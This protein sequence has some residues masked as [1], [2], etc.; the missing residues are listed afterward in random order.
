MEK[1]GRERTPARERLIDIEGDVLFYRV[2]HIFFLTADKIGQDSF[3]FDLFNIGVEIHQE[4]LFLRLQRLQSEI[5]DLFYLPGTVAHPAF[6]IA[7]NLEILLLISKHYLLLGI[8]FGQ[9]LGSIVD[10]RRVTVQ[11]FK[12]MRLGDFRLP[13]LFNTYFNE[14]V[15]A[16]Q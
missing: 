10:H 12:Q 3:Y 2:D 11:A 4:F 6:H 15:N 14:I 8:R 5:D 1:L 16:A 13:F 7:A 9:I